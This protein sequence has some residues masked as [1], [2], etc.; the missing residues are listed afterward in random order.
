MCAAGRSDACSVDRRAAPVARLWQ[1]I[2]TAWARWTSKPSGRLVTRPGRTG[3]TGPQN[4]ASVVLRVSA[5][6]VVLLLAGDVETEAQ[7]AILASGAPIAADVLKF[8][9]HGSGRQSPEFLRAVD[10]G[11]ATISAREGND[12]G[13][14]NRVAL[15]MLKHGGTAWHR[16]DLD[17]DIAIALHDGRLRVVTRR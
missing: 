14:P 16:T 12:Y 1:G 13:H 11:V 17:G 3:L 5:R 7:D 9:H 8:P 6:G 10:A 4:N 2:G 15:N